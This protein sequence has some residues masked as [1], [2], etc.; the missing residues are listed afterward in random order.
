MSTAGD[1][2]V[3]EYTGHACGRVE[4]MPNCVEKNCDDL[5]LEKYARSVGTTA[6]G[7]CK[8]DLCMCVF[9]CKKKFGA[10][11]VTRD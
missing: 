5:C 3:A 6:Q 11:L 1:E 9:P 10:H 2:A 8:G 7:Y 4:N